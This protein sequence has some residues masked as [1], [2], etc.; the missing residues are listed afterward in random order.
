M[1]K[2][3]FDFNKF[4]DVSFKTLTTKF[5]PLPIVLDVL[6][7]Y[8][9]EGVKIMFRFT[10]AIL[11]VHK[12]FVKKCATSAEFI[13]GLRANARINTDPAKLVKAAFKYPLKRGNYDFKKA[14]TH[15]FID[16]K[17]GQ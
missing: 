6:M 8:L 4:V 5:L 11:K 15:G 1:N 10:Y 14:T 2:I 9:V 3:G 7:M 13:D 12:S 16:P 17:T